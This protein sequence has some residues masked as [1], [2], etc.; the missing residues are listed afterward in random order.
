MKFGSKK[1]KEEE[2]AKKR[3]EITRDEFDQICYNTVKRVSENAQRD[4]K[5]FKKTID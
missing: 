1:K 3:N 5:C 2:E 4:H